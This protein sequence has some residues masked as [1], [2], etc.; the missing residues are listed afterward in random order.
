MGHEWTRTEFEPIRPVVSNP[1]T[2]FYDDTSAGTI[3]R[4]PLTHEVAELF[5]IS[6]D[7]MLLML[8]RFFAHTEESEAE[9]AHLSGATLRLMTTVFRPLGG[10]LCKMPVGGSTL[11]LKTAGPGF[12]YIRDVRLLPHQG[13]A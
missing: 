2:P 3:T 5:N 4:G 11:P 6:Y 12:G 13:S 8:L 9:L 10:V 1:M 7:T